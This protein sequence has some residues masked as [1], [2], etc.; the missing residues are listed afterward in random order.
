MTGIPVFSANFTNRTN[1]AKPNYHI[2]IKK[3][4]AILKCVIDLKNSV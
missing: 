2:S 4:Q 1:P 3:T